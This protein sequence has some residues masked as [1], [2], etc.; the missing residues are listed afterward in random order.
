MSSGMHIDRSQQI[1]PKR[2]PNLYISYT[3]KVIEDEGPQGIGPQTRNPRI[4]WAWV[5]G[6]IIHQEYGAEPVTLKR[7]VEE[8]LEK[9]GYSYSESKEWLADA[10]T[11]GYVERVRINK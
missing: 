11:F 2:H 10:L 9:R 7:L 6:D 8:V 3:Q 5:L 1:V 4:N